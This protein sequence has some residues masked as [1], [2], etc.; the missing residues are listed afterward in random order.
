MQPPSSSVELVSPVASANREQANAM[1]FPLPD[2]RSFLVP[3]AGSWSSELSTSIP[4]RP[5]SIS[6]ALA[7]ELFF[8]FFCTSLAANAKGR[9]DSA[10]SRAFSDAM[11][12]SDKVF[13]SFLE[14]DFQKSE[15]I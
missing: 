6:K 12:S 3:L 11:C 7:A 14:I 9:A 5:V 2:L 15:L 1:T 13:L 8:P 10:S 4:I